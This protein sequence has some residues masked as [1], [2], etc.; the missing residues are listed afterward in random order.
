MKVIQILPQMNVG[1][2]ERGVLDLV[3]YFKPKGIT[4][5]VISGGG[6]LVAELEKEGITHYQLPVH[7]KSAAALLSIPKLRKILREENADIIHARSRVPGWIS[8]FA[9][10]NLKTQFITTAHGIYQ[11]KFWSEVMGWGKTV[12]CPSGAVARHMKENFGTPEDK[13]VII[14]RWV[15]LEKFKF[16]DYRQ[17]QKSN[18]IVTVGRISASKGYEYLLQGFKKLVRFNPYL[19][20][21]IIGFPDKSK[22]K[23]FQYLKS[24]VTRYSLNYNVQFA[25]FCPDIE[26]VLRQARMLVAPSIIEESFGRVIVEAFACGVPVLATKV[27]GFTEI[28]EDGKDGILVEP[29]NSNALADGILK[30]MNDPQLAAKLTVNAREKVQ[31]L[32]TAEKCLDTT[33]KVYQETL[34]TVRILVIKISSLGDLILSFPSLAAIKNHFPHSRV[35]LLVAK[36]YYPLVYD[37]PYVDEIITVGSDYKKI[38]NIFALT[39]DFRR[40]SFDYI[41][42]LQNNRASHLIAFLSLAK[43]SLGFSLRAGF[44]L[45]KRTKYQ[46]GDTPL[47]SQERILQLLGIRF[48]ETK[49]LFWNREDKTDLKLGDNSL[50]GINVTA[51]ARWESK[52]WPAKNIIQLIELLAK[53]FPSF[54]VILLGEEEAKEQA[55]NIAAAAGPQVLNLCGK[56]SLSDL[57]CVLKKLKIF[58]T[59]DTATLH[60]AAALGVPTLALFGPTNPERHIVAGENLYVFHRKLSCSFCY[61]PRCR[62]KKENICMKKITPLEVF[63]KI[64][65]LLT[66]AYELQARKEQRLI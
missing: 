50:I 4:S 7:K 23:Y 3:R 10:R 45:S 38:K 43:K 44:L 49:L 12:I 27:G 47:A 15:D 55:A 64:K 56:T 18:I 14:P 52:R 61:Q 48:K 26:N 22:V 65:E 9:T 59:P 34:A 19:K 36:K 53:N 39:K 31:N 5:I 42:D 37:C 35:S 16:S 2:V 58:V 6:R 29:K 28:I 1:G 21:K 54:K 63:N 41:V 60:L 25:G 20:L 46:R 24:L 66:T 40:K 13:I 57:P 11:N 51:A 33:E 17:R 32:Y 8:F 30:I 62:Q